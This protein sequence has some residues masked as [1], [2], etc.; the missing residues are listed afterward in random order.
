MII[1]PLA[2][3]QRSKNYVDN[4]LIKIYDRAEQLEISLATKSSWD[5]LVMG[6][7]KRLKKGKNLYLI[8]EF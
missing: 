1:F 6:K 3:L 4:C 5:V 2:S 7:G 8:N